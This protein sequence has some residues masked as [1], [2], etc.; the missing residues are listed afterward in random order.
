MSLSLYKNTNGIPRG[1][2]FAFVCLFI[3]S[4]VYRISRN[5]LVEGPR[6]KPLNFRL[7][8]LKFEKKF[9]KL[10]RVEEM[11]GGKMLH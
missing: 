4:S 10:L 11:N 8:W 5:I 9:E 6:T 1:Y 3:C 7:I 2:V